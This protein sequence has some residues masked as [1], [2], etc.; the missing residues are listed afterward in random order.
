MAPTKGLKIV[1]PN[2]G[3]APDDPN[4]V[5]EAVLTG[6][7][8]A[9]NGGLELD[10]VTIDGKGAYAVGAGDVVVKNTIIQNVNTGSSGG[11]ADSVIGLEVRGS[12]N[13]VIENV[14]IVNVSGDTADAMGIRIKDAVTGIT[15]NNCHIENVGHNAINIFTTPA[16]TQLD[17]TNNTLINWDS[18]MDDTDGGRAIRI[19]VGAVVTPFTLNITDNTMKAPD[20]AGAGV[21]TPTD[22]EYIKISRISKLASL[23]FENNVIS[24]PIAAQWI[25][26]LGVGASTPDATNNISINDEPVAPVDTKTLTAAD[27]LKKIT[28]TP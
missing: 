16:L 28:V 17:I 15:I 20:Y 5:E 10:G 8:E 27:F 11:G 7:I 19:D 9:S 12:G 26:S 3:L 21:V 13:V 14:K 18:D 2:A 22:L 1:G 6:G 25:L 24:E 23:V 4:R